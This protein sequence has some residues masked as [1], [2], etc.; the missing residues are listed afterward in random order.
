MIEKGTFTGYFNH[1]DL[2]KTPRRVLVIGTIASL[3]TSF[4]YYAIFYLTREVFR[5]VL[6]FPERYT[7]IF[8]ESETNFYNFIFALIASVLGLS[9]FLQ[10]CFRH[11]RC[12]GEKRQNYFRRMSVNTDLTGS[13]SIF[14]CWFS[15]IVFVLAVIFGATTSLCLFSLHPAVWILLVVVLFAEQW[16]TIR[17]VAFHK[18]HY[19]IIFSAIAIVSWSFALSKIQIVDGQSLNDLSIPY[20]C[21]IEYPESDYYR[22][23]PAHR[24]LILDILVCEQKKDTVPLLYVNWVETS[25]EKF[26]EAVTA[27]YTLINEMDQKLVTC[28]IHADRDLPVKHIR[29]IENMLSEIKSFRVG[30]KVIPSDSDCSAQYFPYG[31][32]RNLP[33]PLFIHDEADYSVFPVVIT[34]KGIEGNGQLMNW[35]ELQIAVE[36]FCD[37]N[38][39]YLFTF[40]IEEHFC[41][42]DYIRFYSTMFAAINKIRNRISDERYGKLFDDLEYEQMNEIAKLFPTAIMQK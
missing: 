11:H 21:N 32:L 18:S 5:F 10:F 22:I 9:Q 20:R 40:Q 31:I 30:Y 14:L 4:C 1:E 35:Q 12:F 8:S 19:W 13:S 2:A 37:A 3:V 24:S 15:R 17:R 34:E 36:V 38:P 42:D 39:S 41:Y 25:F 16:K 26:H 33:S 28:F 29:T 7:L 23:I 6:F 27:H